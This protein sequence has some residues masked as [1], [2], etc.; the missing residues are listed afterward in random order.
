MPRASVERG[1]P[2]V[3]QR[4]GLEPGQKRQEEQRDGVTASGYRVSFGDN[5][6]ALELQV[7]IAQLCDYIIHF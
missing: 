2:D 7:M 5:K 3:G 6:N 4:L 1:E